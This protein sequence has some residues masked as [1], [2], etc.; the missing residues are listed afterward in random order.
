[1]APSLTLGPPIGSHSTIEPMPLA[2]AGAGG[3]STK[4]AGPS[5]FNGER[6]SSYPKTGD[7]QTSRSR[8]ASDSILPPNQPGLQ[9][10]VGSNIHLADTAGNSAAALISTASSSVPSP[11]TASRSG[12]IEM[13]LRPSRSRAT[14]TSRTTDNALLNLPPPIPFDLSVKNLWVGVPRSKAPSCVFPS[15]YIP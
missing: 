4:E 1:M 3:M 13:T 8:E 7:G 15:G 10:S 2:G 11:R 14:H 6:I 9:P 12:E 5:S